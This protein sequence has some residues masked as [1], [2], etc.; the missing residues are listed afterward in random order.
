MQVPSWRAIQMLAS[1]D[2]S[3]TAFS[4]RGCES[5]NLAAN[6]TPIGAVSAPAICAI[7]AAED[8]R[9]DIHPG[10]DILSLTRACIHAV[11]TRSRPRGTSTISQQVAKNMWL[12]PARTMA[13][14][15]TEARLALQLEAAL[16]KQRILELYLNTAQFGE[17][18]YGIGSASA[19][20]FGCSPQQLGP[21]ESIRLAGALPAPTRTPPDSIAGAALRRRECKSRRLR[22]RCKTCMKPSGWRVRIS[23]RRLGLQRPLDECTVRA[24]QHTCW[25]QS[26]GACWDGRSLA[27]RS[28]SSS[29]DTVLPEPSSDS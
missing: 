20:Y 24:G 28:I 7:L 25:L 27:P 29:N 10:I 26:A 16:G 2:P 23:M 9:F 19:E 13:R 12:S 4:D 22:K 1:Q 6:W 5:Q 18:S 11:W 14:K 21:M 8:S 17:N 3:S 15:V